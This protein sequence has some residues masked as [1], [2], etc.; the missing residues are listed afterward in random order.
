M[1]T[2]FLLVA[3]SVAAMLAAAQAPWVSTDYVNTPPTPLGLHWA[4]GANS[5]SLSGSCP[6]FVSGNNFVQVLSGTSSQASM[7]SLYP[8]PIDPWSAAIPFNLCADGSKQLFGCPIPGTSGMIFAAC[9]AQ[10]GYHVVAID[11]SSSVT[12]RTRWIAPFSSA[13][14]LYPST[15]F[16]G[17]AATGNTENAMD[18]IVVVTQN[19][20]VHLLSAWTGDALW[21]AP[22]PMPQGQ[23]NMIAFMPSPSTD[24]L[25]VSFLFQ[26][27]LIC[28]DSVGTEFCSNQT[29]STANTY[30]AAQ[31]VSKR[32]GTV[33]APPASAPSNTVAPDTTPF[34]AVYIAYGVN[35]DVEN[36]VR[37]A[38]WQ[39]TPSQKPVQLSDQ[40]V[41]PNP[42]GIAP[43]L[44]VVPSLS[45]PFTTSGGITDVLY[46]AYE[47]V[48]LISFPT[49][50]GASMQQFPDRSVTALTYIRTTPSAVPGIAAAGIEIIAGVAINANSTATT[51]FALN[52][53]ATSMTFAWQK[54]N[55]PGTTFQGQSPMV[56]FCSQRTGPFAAFIAGQISG[57][58]NAE[59]GAYV[60]A[61]QNAANAPTSI[62]GN[63]Y[64]VT[65]DTLVNGGAA[66]TSFF[67]GLPAP[68]PPSSAPAWTEMNVVVQSSAL[69]WLPIWYSSYVNVTNVLRLPAA[70]GNGYDLVV[71][72]KELGLL[73]LDANT[74]AILNG[75]APTAFAGGRKDST[76]SAAFGSRV[77]VGF[78]D[79]EAGQTLRRYVMQV[80][81]VTA[82]A[83]GGSVLSFVSELEIPM[84][85]V[86][87]SNAVIDAST[88]MDLAPAVFLCFDNVFIKIEGGSATSVPAT[89][90]SQT[91]LLL[92]ASCTSRRVVVTGGRAVFAD[93]ANNLYSVQTNAGNPT[94][95]PTIAW[96]SQRPYLVGDPTPA[97]GNGYVWFGSS[98]GYLTALSFGDGSFV[99]TQLIDLG[100]TAHP[101]HVNEPT[102]SL[103]VTSTDSLFVVSTSPSSAAGKL[104]TSFEASVAGARDAAI[105][106]VTVSDAL[107]IAVVVRTTRSGQD[108]GIPTWQSTAYGFNRQ[109]WTTIWTPFTVSVAVMR[110]DDVVL[111]DNLLFLGA[112]RRVYNPY[113]A[114]PFT[115]TANPHPHV[116]LPASHAVVL[117][118]TGGLHFTKYPIIPT[119][120]TLP[121]L[122]TTTVAPSVWRPT[123]FVYTVTAFA[124]AVS[125][126]VV[127]LLITAI[128][129]TVRFVRGHQYVALASEEDENGAAEF[130]GV[131]P[132]TR[133]AAPPASTSAAAAA[134]PQ[135]AA[136]G[137]EATPSPVSVA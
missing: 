24:P 35:A 129:I 116:L 82:N 23:G 13:P 68:P 102:A 73:L 29:S 98:S 133:P 120:V 123:P 61:T 56:Q 109:Y 17:T 76:F 97:A 90:V 11:T 74:G 44:V 14:T 37:V 99:A 104:I 43:Q 9:N 34:A 55:I 122:P 94:V 124:I 31:V 101:I 4:A 86:Q 51:F 27:V 84:T 128:V 91:R 107:D 118:S 30:M 75:G 41:G 18:S 92:P 136:A 19:G 66:A 131:A 113:T 7:T 39:L 49:T 87:F 45:G 6:A 137:D 127:I 10:S 69:R 62:I 54:E 110:C 70:D 89:A 33:I 3:F 114:Q 117:W 88:A 135:P 71:V 5:G 130:E 52:V 96:T 28:I 111:A 80:F 95:A 48:H 32:N 58:I 22:I 63:V 15:V 72:M 53:S 2:V 100:S 85:S 46:V 26:S 38:Q 106:C 36:N 93:A 20:V 112:A 8:S 126:G 57:F 1:P 50:Q 12:T 60:Y 108:G 132:T 42:K 21:P 103:F 134:D 59:T 78:L 83:T 119:P 40:K 115:S 105:T 125:V 64:N 81:D 77:F 65:R 67:K 121:G 16:Q 25:F 47:G 79:G